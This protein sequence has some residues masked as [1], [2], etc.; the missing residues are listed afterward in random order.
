MGTNVKWITRT[1]VLLALCVLFQMI[2]ILIGSTPVSTLI[3][4]SLVNLTLIISVLY[5]GFWSGA[6]LSVFSVIIAYMQGH[7][8]AVIPLAVV[9]ALGNIAIVTG[10]WLFK[11]RNSFV[12]NVSGVLVGAVA[13]FLF[14]WLA[15][16]QFVVPM[17]IANPVKAK[18]LTLAFSY[19]QLITA[20]IGGALAII[21]APRIKHVAKKEA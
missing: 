12:G 14:L 4:G 13:K 3:I 5:V 11:N 1:A 16:S 17:F 9:V 7:I 20:L 8:P 15:V 19:P 6:T 10:V 21:I 2:R 18:A